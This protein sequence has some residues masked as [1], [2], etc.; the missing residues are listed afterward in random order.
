[1]PALVAGLAVFV[2]GFLSASSSGGATKSPASS[3]KGTPVEIVLSGSLRLIEEKTRTVGPPPG[4]TKHGRLL[5]QFEALL[6]DTFGNHQVCASGRW[7]QKFTSDEPLCHVL[8]AKYRHVFANAHNSAFHISS[9]R[10]VGFGNYP[11]PVLIRGRNIACN[12]R[13]TTFLVKQVD[14]AALILRCSRA[15][16]TSP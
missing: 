8:Y 15:G 6:H 12:A 9:R 2:G 5:W 14:A 3:D 10:A 13:E 11:Q 4:L 16:F 7:G 1:V